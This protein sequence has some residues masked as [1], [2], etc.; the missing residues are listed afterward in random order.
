VLHKSKIEADIEVEKNY[1]FTIIDNKIGIGWDKEK[2]LFLV[3]ENY[4]SKDNLDMQI[5]NLLEL[6]ESKQISGN[7]KFDQFY[8]KKKDIS[9]W[10]SSNLFEGF[11]EFDEIENE[12]D[13]DLTDNYVSIYLNFDRDNISLLAE[14]ETNKEIREMIDENNIWDNRFNTNLLSYF[15]D[16]HYAVASLSI[17]TEAYYNLIQENI[18][19]RYAEK[20]FREETGVDLNNLVESISGNAIV[21][22]L[23]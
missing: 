9:L 2:L 10:L 1:S 3:A 21:S 13:I 11:Y 22:I 17:N 6:K 23:K 8:K 19:L 4:D 16:Q 7:E 18:N 5:E 15:P 20:E 12:A 14:L